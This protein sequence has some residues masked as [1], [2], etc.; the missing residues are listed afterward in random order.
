VTIKWSAERALLSMAV[1]DWYGPGHAKAFVRQVRPELGPDQARVIAETAIRRL[2]ERGLIRIVRRN[3]LTNQEIALS[4]DEIDDVL[5]DDRWW[6]WYAS[7]SDWSVAFMATP[8]GEE[9]HYE[10]EFR[11]QTPEES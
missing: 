6:K 9:A 2:L 10:G 11:P 4:K 5:N 1:E 7:D 8:E 3:Y